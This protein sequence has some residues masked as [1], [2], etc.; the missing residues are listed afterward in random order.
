MIIHYAMG[1]QMSATFAGYR[2]SQLSPNRQRLLAVMQQHN[3]CKIL[4][5]HVSDGEPVF[6]PDPTVIQDLKIG[7]NNDPRIEIHLR[8]YVLKQAHV[9]LFQHLDELRDGIVDELEVR[10]G[11]PQQ[12]KI[13]RTVTEV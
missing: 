9:E 3:F 8:D 4:Q 2:K 5:L 12:L 1:H 13:K 7:G 6:D 10:Y 11:L